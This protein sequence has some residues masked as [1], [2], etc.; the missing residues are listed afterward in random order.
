VLGELGGV[1]DV[2]VTLAFVVEVGAVLSQAKRFLRVPNS[3][4][5]RHPT[6]DNTQRSVVVICS[7]SRS[8]GMR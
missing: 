1:L 5:L 2:K 4:S 3:D 6:P 8:I 7:K